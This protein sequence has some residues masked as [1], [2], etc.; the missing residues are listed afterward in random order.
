MA[1][2]ITELIN[3]IGL[4]APTIL[5]IL[6]LFFTRKFKNYSYFF[7]IGFI[8]NFILNIIL[9]LLIRE[10]RPDDDQK[11]IEIGIVNGGRIGFDK[12]GM[13]SG[14]AQ[15]CAYCLAFVSLLWNSPLVTAIYLCFTLVSMVQRYLNKN[16]TILQLLVGLIVGLIVGYGSY[17]L[18]NKYITG[19]IKM[20]LD[21]FAPL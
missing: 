1:L 3:Y 5:F 13:P 11:I 18:A 17:Y 15:T 14:H 9:K 12:Y 4:Y 2:I 19:N 21:D 7:V 6:T 20:K 16:H 10:P 8:F